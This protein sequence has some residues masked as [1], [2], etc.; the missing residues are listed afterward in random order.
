[1]DVAAHLQPQ[2]SSRMSAKDDVRTVT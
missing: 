2:I 1:V